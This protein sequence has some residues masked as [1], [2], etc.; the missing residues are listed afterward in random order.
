VSVAA[1]PPDEL[2][3]YAAYGSNLSRERLRLYLEGGC[4]PGRIHGHPG[5]ADP[6]PPRA[7]HPAVLPLPLRFAG[8]GG[9]GGGV[10]FVDPDPRPDVRTYARLWLLTRGQVAD[11]VAQERHA[12]VE[13]VDIDAVVR[14]GRL[15]V[16]P[17]TYGE[18]VACVPVELLTGAAAHDDHAVVTI[19]GGPATPAAPTAD[20]LR[21]IADGLAEAH[22][23][24]VAAAAA[25]LAAIPGAAGAWSPEQLRAALAGAGRAAG[26]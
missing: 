9:W 4:P 19:T 23:L 10:A 3:W 15:R 7:D 2:V 24:D 22:G 14:H 1:S 18:V 16:G 11:L 21:T 26:S 25:Y 13:P 20:Y 6:S 17:G 12:P 8:A 5:C